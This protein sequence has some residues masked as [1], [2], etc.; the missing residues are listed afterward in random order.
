MA[1]TTIQTKAKQAV[2]SLLKDA[3]DAGWSR[4]KF[5]L[6]PDGSVTVD[7]GMGDPSG[8]DDFLES[9]LRMGK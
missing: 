7:A 8:V 3:R 9:D 4:A 2:S 1:K 6:K 5:E